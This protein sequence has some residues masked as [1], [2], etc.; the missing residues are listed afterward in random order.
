VDACVLI[1]ICTSPH[2]T[3]ILNS[4]STPLVAVRQVA[5][6]SL[7]IEIAGGSGRKRQQI[8]VAELARRGLVE[9]IDLHDEEL[10]LF[11]T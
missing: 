11:I 2:A 8:E 7:Y 4:Q 9:I 10:S 6:E 3:A 1:N 5:N